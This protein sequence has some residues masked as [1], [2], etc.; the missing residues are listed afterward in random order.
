MTTKKQCNTTG[1]TPTTDNPPAKSSLRRFFT[2]QSE[3]QER[4]KMAPATN[5]R[6]SQPPSPSASEESVEDTDIRT[7]LTQLPSKN[8][9]IDM[10]QRLENTFS[11]K[12]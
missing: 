7:I 4:N 6:G 8:D 12:L 2:E 10:F 5:T 11:E 3:P 9:L 1:N